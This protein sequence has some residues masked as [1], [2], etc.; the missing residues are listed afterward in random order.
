MNW[1][2][3]F[4][5]MATA[6]IAYVLGWWTGMDKGVKWTVSRMCDRLS[7]DG[8]DV[9]EMMNRWDRENQEQEEDSTF[10]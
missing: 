2:L 1:T 8:I 3:F 4:A 9:V 7:R 5:F 6:A 10:R